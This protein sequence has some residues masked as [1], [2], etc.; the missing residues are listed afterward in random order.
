MT[1]SLRILLAILLLFAASAPKALTAHE[2]KMIERAT[3]FFGMLTE[4][5]DLVWIDTPS[6]T[7]FAGQVE[8][9]SLWNPKAELCVPKPGCGRERGL[10]FGQM[11]ITPRF[12]VFQ[13]VALL[14]PALRGWAPADYF[15][16]R[17]QLIAVVAKD[18]LHFKQCGPLFTGYP[19]VMACMLSSYNGGF[20]GVQADRR[21][22][23]NTKGCDPFK[24]YSNVEDTSL[25][26]KTAQAGYGQSFYQINRGYVKQVWF[27]KSPKYERHLN[28]SK[29]LPP[30][31]LTPAAKAATNDP[32]LVP[33]P[34][35]MAAIL[36]NAVAPAPAKQANWL[37]RLFQ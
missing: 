35:P 7:V 37:Q 14:H 13:E 5:T 6:R 2:A 16:P 11:T 31:V 26:A 33:P 17:L 10:G 32:P 25:K 20:G 28:G 9:E 8:K 29:P 12:N 18:K 21:L 36:P 15:D 3:P 23:G 27:E 30:P 1:S 4:A 22:C 34:K 24:W 19:E